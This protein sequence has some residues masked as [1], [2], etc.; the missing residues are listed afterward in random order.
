[1]R[2]TE[3]LWTCLQACS[4]FFNA[5]LSMPL[6]VLV[7]PPCPVV[8]YV[9]FVLVTMTRLL[10]LDDRDWDV[11]LAR[12]TADFPGVCLRLEERFQAADNF[13]MSIRPARRGKL[14]DEARSTCAAYVDKFRWLRQWYLSKPSVEGQGPRD[15]GNSAGAATSGLGS[16]MEVD[17]TGWAAVP[18]DMD[19]DFWNSLI[20]LDGSLGALSTADL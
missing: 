7:A 15:S 4:G 6:D 1:M 5:I 11:V 17:V 12:K 16:A 9:S 3:G 19:A 18:G 14:H 13:A 2:R 20:Q 10:F 8:A